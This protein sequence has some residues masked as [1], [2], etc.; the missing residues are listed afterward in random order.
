MPPDASDS[1][2]QRF[3]RS[4]AIAREAWHDGVGYDLDALRAASP[5]ERAQ[6]EALLTPRAVEDWRDVQA[7]AALG[8]AGARV[9]LQRALQA[10]RP[11]IRA[12]VLRYCPEVVGITRRAA[13]LVEILEGAEDVAALADAFEQIVDFHPPPVVTALL[14]AARCAPADVAVHCAAM[15]CFLHGQAA[16]PFDWGQRPFFLQFATD[17]DAERRAAFQ[18]LCDRIGSDA[19]H[20]LDP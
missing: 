18:S 12:A 2:L 15:L 9:A 16:E 6:L 4:M 19:H 7:L 5:A 8:T 17:D 20:H 14:R 3:Q 10:G 1:P 11:E 13:A